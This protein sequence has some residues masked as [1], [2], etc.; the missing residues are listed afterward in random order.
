[1]NFK[2]I[3]AE[4]LIADYDR[5]RIDSYYEFTYLRPEEE[6]A[7]TSRSHRLHKNLVSDGPEALYS[8]SPAVKWTESCN[9][10]S[11]DCH[12]LCIRQEGT[13]RVKSLAYSTI[14][15]SL[16][17]LSPTANIVYEALRIIYQKGSRI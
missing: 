11:R 13:N 6:R 15:A 4:R 7:P 10:V 8:P 9:L 1:M 2:Y 3:V 16:A 14:P 5:V 17:Y 12:D